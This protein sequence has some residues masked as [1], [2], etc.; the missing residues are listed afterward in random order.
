MGRRKAEKPSNASTRCSPILNPGITQCL[1]DLRAIWQLDSDSAV[2][3]RALHESRWRR[4][5]LM[6]EANQAI[7]RL[8][9]DPG[10]ESQDVLTAVASRIAFLSHLQTIG[11]GQD[12]PTRS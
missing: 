11:P 7:V 1:S 9:K 8:A 6:L 2:I 3:S 4:E 12:P 5:T 10:I